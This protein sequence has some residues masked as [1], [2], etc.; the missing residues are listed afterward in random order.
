MSTAQNSGPGDLGP[1][2]RLEGPELQARICAV[3][4]HAA[5]VRIADFEDG[6]RSGAEQLRVL[7]LEALRES[8]TAIATIQGHYETWGAGDVEVSG[9]GRG[10]CETVERHQLRPSSVEKIGDLAFVAGLGLR[11]RAQSVESTAGSDDKWEVI[12]ECSGAFRE[13]LKSLTALER[14]VCECEGIPPRSSYYV[15]ELERALLTRRAYVKL[16]Q[17]VV[18]PR[19]EGED[20]PPRL[21]RA[22]A[23]IAKMVSREI[24]V[25]ARVHD[26]RMIRK[27]Q[28]RIQSWLSTEPP[29]EDPRR[30]AWLLAGMRLHRDLANVCDLLLAINHRA[31]LRAHDAEILGA[32]LEKLAA[33][34]PARLSIAQELPELAGVLGRDAQVDALLDARSTVDAAVA[35]EIVRRALRTVQGQ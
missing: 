6:D 8:L 14:A 11:S 17:D 5:A 35:A 1:S 10:L 33:R 15:T 4:D 19:P 9:H 16:H 25:S 13:I 20:I 24:Y 12:S 26:R 3:I 31:E 22:A 7:S 28:E 2:R 30:V 18:G 32:A 27:V 21:R 23:S 29:S 34:A